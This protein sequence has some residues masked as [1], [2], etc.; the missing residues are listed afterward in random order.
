MSGFREEWVGPLALVAVGGCL[1]AALRHGITVLTPGVAT[2]QDPITGTLAANVLGSFLLGAM[3][4]DAGAGQVVPTRARLLVGTGVLSSLTTYSTFAVQTSGLGP[5]LAAL[6]VAA[7][8]GLG[9]VAVVCG[10]RLA[11][12]LS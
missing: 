6:N 3:A 12:W 11:G 4:Y 2:L 8:Y 7:N 1:G 5:E 9:F 10:Q